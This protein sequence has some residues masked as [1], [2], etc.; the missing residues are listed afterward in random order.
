MVQSSEVPLVLNVQ[1]EASFVDDD[2]TVP[3]CVAVC[4]T[5]RSWVPSG[6]SQKFTS[7]NGEERTDSPSTNSS[8][9]MSALESS[10][11]VLIDPS[12]KSSPPSEYVGTLT[13]TIVPA[14]TGA[15]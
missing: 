14:R 12:W 1:V 5:R 2:S 10:A 4:T 8:V 15:R 6:I 9:V 7:E 13:D 3:S 11:S